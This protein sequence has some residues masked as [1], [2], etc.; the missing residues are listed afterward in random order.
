MKEVTGGY[1][2]RILSLDL[3]TGDVEDT[4]TEVYS[5]LFLGGRGI[6]AKM[7]WDDVPPDVSPFDPQ[8]RLIFITGPVTA[9]T[10]FCGSRWQ[11][12]GKSPLHDTFS[13]CNLGGNWGAPEPVNDFETP[14]GSI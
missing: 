2:G 13:Y 12:C 10:G 9:T 1:A 4:P 6:A 8:N 5:P 3:S 7:Y 14:V 11:V